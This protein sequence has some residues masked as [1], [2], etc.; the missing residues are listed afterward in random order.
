MKKVI[1]H[2][3][4]LP[5][6]EFLSDKF[7]SKQSVYEVIRI[8]DGVAIFLEDH[9]RRLII[10]MENLGFS[11]EMGFPEF[12]QKIAD[13]VWLNQKMDGNIRFVYSDID[14]KGQWFFAFIPS[15]YPSK[16]D[17]RIGVDT[18]LIYSERENPNAKVINILLRDRA[19]QILA[20][21]KLY[22][23]LL[24]DRNG[25][26]TEGSRS[27]VFFVKDDVFYTAQASKVLVGITRQ[28]VMKCL[29]ELEFQVIEEA[30]GIDE[31]SRFD[32]VFLTGTSPKVLPVKSIGNQVFNPLLPSVNK[33]IDRYNGMIAQYIQSEKTSE[34]SN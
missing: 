32:G 34:R 2:A 15:I 24:V 20:S 8:I 33:L 3:G 27:N 26:I 1:T 18:G 22:E 7:N 23:V 14:N 21:S 10:S 12:K 25:Q 28:K 31:I 5:E 6:S 9:F 11:F 16:K 13:L 4:E 30:V 17:Y 19:N 29:R